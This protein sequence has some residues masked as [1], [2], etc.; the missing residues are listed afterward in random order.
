MLRSPWKGSSSNCSPRRLGSGTRTALASDGGRPLWLDEARDLLH[1]TPGQSLRVGEVAEAIGVH[2]VHLTRTFRAH[3]GV[4]VGAYLRNL[5]LEQ[6][7]QAL[8]G[9]TSTIA[10]IAAQAGFYDQSHFT[11]TFKRKYGLTPHDYR[12]A[13]R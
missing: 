8:A 13:A 7:A 3:F 10:D 11:R 4:S 5:R 6:A 2:P 9:S 1:A 12:R